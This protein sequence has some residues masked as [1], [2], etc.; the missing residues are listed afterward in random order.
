MNAATNTAAGNDELSRLSHRLSALVARS[1]GLTAALV[2]FS[3]DFSRL[4][5]EPPSSLA[6]MKS[7]RESRLRAYCDQQC[8]TGTPRSCLYDSRSKSGFNV[9][10]MARRTDLY[11][12]DVRSWLS[13]K[14]RTDGATDK[15]FGRLFAAAGV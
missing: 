14:A 1:E 7:Q 9:S 13:G 2:E 4:A 3:L 12:A 5:N 15:A 6:E 11:P 10:E 8:M